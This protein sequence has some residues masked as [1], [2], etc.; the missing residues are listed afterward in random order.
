MY[1]IKYL[2]KYKQKY[3]RL[4]LPLSVEQKLEDAVNLLIMTGSLNGK[5]Q[6]HKLHKSKA[7]KRSNNSN[8]NREFH[9]EGNIVVRY[10]VDENSKTVF[11]VI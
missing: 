6:D 11:F 8:N 2:A 1:K 9:L 10:I 4:R 5:Y 7:T 3:K